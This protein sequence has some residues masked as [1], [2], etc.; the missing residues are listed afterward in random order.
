MLYSIAHNTN[1]VIIKE[2]SFSKKDK[3]IKLEHRLRSMM[4]TLMDALVIGHK[5]P[6]P[7]MLRLQGASEVFRQNNKIRISICKIKVRKLKLITI[8]TILLT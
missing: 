8:Q 6:L 1:K 7:R 4:L 3:I 5:P 2:V